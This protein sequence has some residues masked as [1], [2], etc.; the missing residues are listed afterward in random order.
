MGKENLGMAPEEADQPEVVDMGIVHRVE[1][2]TQNRNPYHRENRRE[3]DPN[4]LSLKAI[5]HAAS[6]DEYGNVVVGI[7]TFRRVEGTVM[8]DGKPTPVSSANLYDRGTTYIGEVMTAHIASL[9]EKDTE[10]QKQLRNHREE[11]KV[12][13]TRTGH[14]YPFRRGDK[15]ISLPKQGE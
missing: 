14:Y 15:V 1:L 6:P 10:F 4:G 12:V 5:A 8:V 13:R 3:M 7:R 9:F 2:V 11:D